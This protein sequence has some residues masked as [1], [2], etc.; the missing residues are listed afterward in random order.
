MVMLRA[1]HGPEVDPNRTA[2]H[3]KASVLDLVLSN[4]PCAPIYASAGL[5]FI[6]NPAF[7]SRALKAPEPGLVTTIVPL[8]VTA[9]YPVA[10]LDWPDV[11][12]DYLEE[13]T[14]ECF[15][16]PYAPWLTSVERVVVP[17]PQRQ[18][19]ILERRCIGVPA[20]GARKSDHWSA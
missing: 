13:A 10:A 14:D 15:L 3:L 18:V 6:S 1:E 7:R 5:M 19:H 11:L 16:Q 12:F 2:E 17:L 9:L 4:P 8:L 20:C